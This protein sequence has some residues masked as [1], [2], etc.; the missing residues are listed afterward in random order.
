MNIRPVADA[1]VRRIREIYAP[2]ILHSAVSFELDLPSEEDMLQRI[3]QYT[4][5]YPWLVAEENG[6]VLGY[7]Y[8]SSYRE[9]K[10]YR[11]CVET[12][13]YIDPTAARKGMASLLYEKLFRELKEKGFT[14]AFALITQ[15]NEASVSFH[16]SQGFESVALF[17]SVGYK[18]D[19]WHDV[20]WMRKRI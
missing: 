10:A 8:A 2:H 15:P 4:L 1:D 13:V 19:R 9:R 17:E 20:L 7:A 11:F 16:R 3:R 5:Q 14:Q 18:F 6:N 12:S